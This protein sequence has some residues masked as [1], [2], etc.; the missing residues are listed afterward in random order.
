MM[1]APSLFGQSSSTGALTG[2]LQDSSGAVQDGLPLFITDANGGNIYGNVQI[3]TGNY[4]AGMGSANVPTPGSDKARLGG[5]IIGGPGWFNKAAFAP[6]ASSSNNGYGNSGYGSVLG[7]GQFNW[8][9]SLVKTTKV[10]GIHEDASLVFR[11]EFFN[12][13][14]HAQFSNPGSVDL[15]SSTFGQITSSSVNPRLI[16]FALKYVF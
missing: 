1:V 9:I 5:P 7:P 4:A 6:F 14:N 11:T 3:S 10:G 16:Q 12:A 13:F 15:T 8:D 2:T